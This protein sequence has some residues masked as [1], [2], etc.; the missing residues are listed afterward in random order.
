MEQIIRGDRNSSYVFWQCYG[1]CVNMIGSI[2]KSM[3]G[4]DN[5]KWITFYGKKCINWKKRNHV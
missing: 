1:S 4:Q 5:D 2:E 3:M